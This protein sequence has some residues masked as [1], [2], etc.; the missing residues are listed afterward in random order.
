MSPRIKQL[1][2]EAEMYVETQFGHWPKW[3]DSKE[4]ELAYERF[5]KLI[6]QECIAIN[7]QQLSFTAFEQLLNKYKDQFGE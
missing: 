7:K 3:M 1:A 2:I 5:A 4:C 6:V